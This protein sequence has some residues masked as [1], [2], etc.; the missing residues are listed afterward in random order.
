MWSIFTGLQESPAACYYEGK[1][2]SPGAIVHMPGQ[3]NMSCARAGSAPAWISLKK[4][5]SISS[6]AA[7]TLF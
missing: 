7:G 4:D 6:T 2:Y 5:L 3:V 1:A